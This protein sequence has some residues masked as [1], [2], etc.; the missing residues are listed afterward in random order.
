MSSPA[1][2]LRLSGWLW[3]CLALALWLP[4]WL[5]WSEWW[6]S[7]P[8]QTHGWLVPVFALWLGRDRWRDAPAPAMG[9]GGAWRMLLVSTGLAGA[10]ATWTA[11]LVLLTPNAFWPTAQW[12]AGVGAAAGW[13]FAAAGAGG[14]RWAAHFAGAALFPLCAAA[15]PAAVQ[16]PV[17]EH[18]GPAIAHLAAELVNLLGRLAVAQ[19]SVI[20]V[21][22]GWVGV[23]EACAGLRSLDAAVM[24]AWFIG[25]QRRLGWRSRLALGAIALAVAILGNLFRAGTLV[26]VA[27]GDGPAAT[28]TW[29]D[30]LGWAVLVFTLVGVLAAGEWLEHGHSGT[31]R[32]SSRPSSRSPGPAFALA[33]LGLAAA[34]WTAN[35]LWYRPADSAAR[36]VAW[37][38][39]APDE[40]WRPAPTPSGIK[41]LLHA[42]RW[43]GLAGEGSDWRGLAYLIAWEGDIAAAENAFIH[44]P[45]ICLPGI[46]LHPEAQI[47]RVQV[48]AAGRVLLLSGTRYT[49]ATGRIQHVWFAR[50][51][52]AEAR[53]VGRDPSDT[54]PAATRL[55][56]VKARR[57]SA[58]LAQIILVSSGPTSDESALRWAREWAPRL[59][60][61]I[62]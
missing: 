59:L 54:S 56:G 24:M 40:T 49:D 42:T 25:E 11:G 51:D 28:R 57:G 8:E 61:R 55:A 7:R 33:A 15:W 43:Q 27:A 53:N 4:V 23:D 16:V 13:L 35:A 26:W 38:L 32:A 48:S 18:L 22:D 58:S 44:G 20:E 9:N 19:G 31:A 37:S 29:H 60:H 6:A 62:Q 46:G 5:G 3:P 36:P 47:G 21:A 10:L 52:E 39:V 30:P 1:R 2:P 45:E 17:I 41:T 50:W 34:G 12:L 14:T